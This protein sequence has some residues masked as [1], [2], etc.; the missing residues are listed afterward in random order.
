VRRRIRAFLAVNAAL[1]AL[2]GL[3][4]GVGCAQIA[5]R[6]AIPFLYEEA[7]LPES[8]ILRD[9]AYRDDFGAD[10]LKHRLDVFLPASAAPVDGAHANA[11]PLLVFV[12]G[13]G[14]TSGDKAL[15]VGGADVYAN[16]GRFFAAHGIGAAVISYRLQPEVRWQDQVDDVERAVAVL[17]ERVAGWGGDPRAIFLSGHSAGAQLATWAALAPG[18]VPV[19]GLIPISGAGF[20][21]A[22]EETYLLGASRDYYAERFA[23][24]SRDDAWAESASVVRLVRAALP[25][26]LILYAEDDY[27]ALQRQARV[28]DEALRAQGADSRVVVVPDQS[29]TSIVLTLSRDDRTAAPAM[30]AFIRSHARS[31]RC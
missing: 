14:W 23:N 17:R 11:W 27:A 13:G 19:C 18:A 15:R 2:L 3:A 25:P 7:E 1:L 9:V 6:V 24:G 16:I 22:D 21:L 4:G 12:H 30:L 29:H 8:Q 31:P 10:P 20:D 26:A 5:Y 28:L